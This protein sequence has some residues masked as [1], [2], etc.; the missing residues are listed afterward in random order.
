MNQIVAFVGSLL[1][2]GACS[3]QPRV[4]DTVW[5]NRSAEIRVGF[6]C[7]SHAQQGKA[8]RLD[9]REGSESAYRLVLS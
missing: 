7:L 5:G 3:V 8:M 9:R 6:Q 2:L 4:Q 1:S